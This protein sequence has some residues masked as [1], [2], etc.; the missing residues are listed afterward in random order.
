M[1][2]LRGLS[3]PLK[4]QLGFNGWKNKGRKTMGK[5]EVQGIIVL[6]MV[7]LAS[8]GSA[9]QSGSGSSF[10]ARLSGDEEVPA[11]QTQARGEAKFELTEAAD[12]LTYSIMIENIKNVTS[13]QIH[14]GR[15]GENGP[16]VVELFVE[17][18]KENING[19]L[20]AEGKIEP[21]LLTGPLK[22]QSL[23]CLVQLMETGETYLTIQTQ[24]HP[25]GEIRG[26][27]IK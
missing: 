12:G 7:L 8:L 1:R 9:D 19:T 23:C 18:K 20:L 14:Q 26:Q 11:V 15:R 13:A 16:P 25:D 5:L 2:N 3:G 21:Y 4:R 10:K 17:P 6:S 27:I 22:G 24:N